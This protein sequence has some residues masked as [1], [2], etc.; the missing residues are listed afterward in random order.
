MVDYIGDSALL[1][2]ELYGVARP[3]RRFESNERTVCPPASH[4]RLVG[5]PQMPEW[6]GGE[7]TINIRKKLVQQPCG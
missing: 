1:L 5:L 7:I 3:R 4:R 6:G 2:V